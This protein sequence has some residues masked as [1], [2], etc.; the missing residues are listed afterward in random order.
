[1]SNLQAFDAVA[2][3]ATRIES[4]RIRFDEQL[5]INVP[6]T[7]VTFAAMHIR[8]LEE[9]L[10]KAQQQLEDVRKSASQPHH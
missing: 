6:T 2:S 3:R 4:S 8:M 10:A 1:M 7:V 5:A 9:Q